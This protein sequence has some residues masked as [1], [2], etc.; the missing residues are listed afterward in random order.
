MRSQFYRIRRLQGALGVAALGLAFSGCTAVNLNSLHNPDDLLP[1]ADDTPIA[2]P[3]SA[4]RMLVYE[5]PGALAVFHGTTCAQSNLSGMEEGMRVQEQLDLPKGL[6]T[7]TVLLNGYGR[8]P[9][10]EPVLLGVARRC[11]GCSRFS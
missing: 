3:T 1:F 5:S 6:N 8:T 2:T 11:Q 4:D 7:A 10:L 9:Q